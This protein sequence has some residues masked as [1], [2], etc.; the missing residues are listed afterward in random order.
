M[1]GNADN[2]GKLGRGVVDNIICDGMGDREGQCRSIN[3]I[4]EELFS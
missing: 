1:G 3:G 2:L 4:Q